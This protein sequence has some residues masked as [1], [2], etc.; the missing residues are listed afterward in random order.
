MTTNMEIVSGSVRQSFAAEGF[1]LFKS[2]VP[3]DLVT[4]ALKRMD[5]VIAGEYKTGTAPHHVHFDSADPIDKLRKIDQPHLCDPVIHELVSHRAIGQAVAS[6]HNASFIQVWATQLLLKPP[7][8]SEAGNIGWHQDMQHWS[9]YWRGEVGTVWLALSEVTENSGPMRFV[10][11]SH[12][13]GLNSNPSF[14]RDPDHAAQREA[15]PRPHGAKWEEVVAL[16]KPGDASFHHRFTYHGSGPNHS[17]EPRCSFAIHIRT[18]RSEPI[19]GDSY[20]T[21][22]LDDDNLCPVIYSG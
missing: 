9:S 14:F 15:I 1:A 3:S 11:G 8:T 16:M 17:S 18:E 12:R 4:A 6:L 13:W 2:V 5:A 10:R 20:Y 22:H 19:F 21:A 7:S